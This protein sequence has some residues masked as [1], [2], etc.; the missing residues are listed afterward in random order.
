MFC[1]L[2]QNYQYFFWKIIWASWSKLS[3]KLKNGIKTYIG[4]AFLEFLIKTHC[5]RFSLLMVKLYSWGVDYTWFLFIYL[6]IFFWSFFFNV[7]NSYQDE[8][9]SITTEEESSRQC[10][11]T[12]IIMGSYNAQH[13]CTLNRVLE[14]PLWGNASAQEAATYTSLQGGIRGTGQNLTGGI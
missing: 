10:K 8:V 13:I 3:Q 14:A 4:Q 2:S 9:M 11:F 12:I 1:A 7:E 6:F 5:F